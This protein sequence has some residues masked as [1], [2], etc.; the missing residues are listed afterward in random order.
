MDSSMQADIQAVARYVAVDRN[1]KKILID[2][3]AD[4]GSSRLADLV[5]SKDRVE[6]V[7]AALVELGG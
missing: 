1:I 6:N 4:D 7:V 5:L 3:H 2:G